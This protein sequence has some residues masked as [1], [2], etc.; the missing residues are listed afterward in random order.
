[1]ANPKTG[2][3]PRLIRLIHVAKRDLALDDEAYRDMVEQVTGQTSAAALSVLQLERLLGHMKKCGFKVKASIGTRT[4]AQ[5]LQAS[6]MRALWLLLHQAD[7]V[8]DSSE[9][10]LASYVKRITGVEALQWLNTAQC[11]LVIESLK[12]WCKRTG[13]EYEN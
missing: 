10:A 11:S 13:V 7:V 8:R 3:K 9:Q 5:S 4:Q 12:K 2:D 6:K 1:M